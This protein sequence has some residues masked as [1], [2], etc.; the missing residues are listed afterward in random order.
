MNVQISTMTLDD[1]NNIKDILTSEFDDF[2]TYSIL[3]SE[4]E[5]PLSQ[6][7]V[8]KVEEEI[9]GFSGIIDTVEQME[10]TNIVVKKNMRKKGIG[11]L[12]LKELILLSKGKNN[13]FLEVNAKNINAIKLYEKNGFKNCGIR[14]KYYN[15]TDDAILMKLELN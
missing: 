14:K 13:I 10:I 6:Y 8:A 2:W 11:N 7:I 3:K 9:V 1:L 4:L 15:G 12:L 5:N